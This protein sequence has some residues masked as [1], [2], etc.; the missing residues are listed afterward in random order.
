M[1]E[2]VYVYAIIYVCRGKTGGG[3]LLCKPNINRH[4]DTSKGAR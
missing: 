2:Y 3:R 4:A 1:F